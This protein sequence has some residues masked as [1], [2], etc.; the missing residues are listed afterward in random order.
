V[1]T[2]GD[3]YVHDESATLVANFWRAIPTSRCSGAIYIH[4]PKIIG[5]TDR[6]TIVRP[7]YPATDCWAIFYTAVAG[8]KQSDRAGYESQTNA[9]DGPSG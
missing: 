3:E 1:W 2:D 6:N 4:Q 8:A 7:E 5:A 9:A